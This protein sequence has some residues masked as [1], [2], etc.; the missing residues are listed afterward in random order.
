MIFLHVIIGLILGKIFGNTTLFVIASILPDIDH[1]YVI[2]KNRLFSFRKIMN[3]LKNEERYNIRFKT[4]LIHSLLGLVICSIIYY[5]IFKIDTAYFALAY[6]FHLLLDWPDKDIK[7]YFYP[8]KY[9]FKGFLPIWSRAEQIVTILAV[10]FLL[11]LYI[12]F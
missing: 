8:I 4:P 6:I 11:L 2:I 9:N 5:L 3:A 12:F 10:V 1:V 7:Q